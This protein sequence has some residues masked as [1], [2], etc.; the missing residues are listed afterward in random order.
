MEGSSPTGLVEEVDEFVKREAG[1][2]RG[3]RLVLLVFRGLEGPIDEEGASDEVAE[4][5]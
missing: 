3:A 2:F 4:R 5:D 1:L